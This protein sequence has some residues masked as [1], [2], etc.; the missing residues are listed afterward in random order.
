[1]KNVIFYLGLGMLFTHEL[2]AVPNHEWRVLPILRALSDDL[3][4]DIFVLAHVPIFAAI[5]AFV[6]SPKPQVRAKTRLIIAGFLAVHGLLHGFFSGQTAYEFSSS[7][8]MMLIYGAAGLG[9]LYLLAE[10]LERRENAI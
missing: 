1:M 5:I 4:A 3:G 2:D 9:V 7:S 10:L 6:A 8:S